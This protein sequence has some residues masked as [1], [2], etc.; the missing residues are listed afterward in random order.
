MTEAYV[1]AF[2]MRRITKRFPGVVANDAVDFSAARGEIHAL[3]GENGAGKSTLMN[4]LCGLYRQDEGEIFINGKPVEFHSPGDAIAAGVGMVHQHFMLVPVQSVA[5]NVILGLRGVSFVLNTAEIEAEVKRIGEQYGLPVDPR[6]KIWQLSVGEQQRV[7]I[8]K[9][10]YRGAQI[11]ILDEPTAVLTP[12]ETE[13]FFRTLNEMKADGKTIVFISHKLDEVLAIADR[14]TVARERPEIFKTLAQE[15]LLDSEF[16]EVFAAF[17]QE[18][19]LTGIFT[20]LQQA[21]AR[22]EVRDL[23]EQAMLRAIISL[24]AGYVV[25]RAILA[26]QAAWDDEAEAAQIV[27]I[28]LQGIGASPKEQG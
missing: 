28:L 24:T 6:A 16:R 23:P 13:L 26:P 1:P 20:I 4:V 3:L 27:D 19:L 12:Q 11:L 25:Q 17:W 2:E 14:I 15:L 18:Q 8:I 22:G 9:M 21:K 7:E 10:L 5:E